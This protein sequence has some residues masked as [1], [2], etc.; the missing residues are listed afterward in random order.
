MSFDKNSTNR[1]AVAS[2]ILGRVVYGI[3]WWNIAAVFSLIASE[4]Q[5]DISGLGVV[6]AAF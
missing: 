5:Q 1:A 4:F 3:N 2:L 6:T